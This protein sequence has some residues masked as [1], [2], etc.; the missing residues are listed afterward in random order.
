MRG[1]AAHDPYGENPG[2]EAAVQE[3]MDRKEQGRKRQAERR[4]REQG[5]EQRTAA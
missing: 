4:Q 2:M 1:S 3:G 5:D